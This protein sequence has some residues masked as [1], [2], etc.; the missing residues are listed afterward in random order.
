[1]DASK[2]KP[3][4][5]LEGLPRFL[6]GFTAY[7]LR[8][9]FVAEREVAFGGKWYFLPR[10]ALGN[11]LM[12]SPRFAHLYTELFKPEPQTGAD[13][14]QH[15]SA[16]R[17]VV[18]ADRPT[19]RGLARREPLDLYITIVVREERLVE[20]FLAFLPEWQGYNFMQEHGLSYHSYQLLSPETGRYE[21]GL[22]VGEARLDIGFFERQAPEWVE[23]LSVRFLTP[24]TLRLDQLLSAEIP[25][26]RLLNRISRRLYDLYTQCLASEGE[27]VEPFVFAE[28]N[29][30]VLSEVSLPQSPTIKA[31]RQ[32][33]MSGIL[34][35]LHYRTPYDPVAALMLSVA[36]WVHIGTHTVSGNGQILAWGTDASAQPSPSPSSS[37]D[38]EGCLVVQGE[39]LRL[40]LQRL[41]LVIRQGGQLVSRHPATSIR[42]LRLVGEAPSLSSGVLSFCNKRGIPILHSDSL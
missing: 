3:R 26:S 27:S 29:D 16:S 34:G 28:R 33:D 11:A 30:L 15:T 23:G 9:R 24:T 1:M 20:D 41:D 4:A 22:G 31:H 39:G 5:G 14:R 21:T 32:Y 42:E 12:N 40:G 13:G 8:V 6:E 18:R 10:F 35:Q 38:E 19:R 7:H 36:H 37:L 2:S 25:L 17:L